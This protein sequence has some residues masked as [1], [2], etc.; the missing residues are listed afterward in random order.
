VYRFESHDRAG[1]DQTDGC[2][3]AVYA[4]RAG[5]L[6]LPFT[7]TVRLGAIASVNAE[8]IRRGVFA[9]AAD[10]IAYIA[11]AEYEVPAVAS[12]LAEY[13]SARGRIWMSTPRAIRAAL[14][15]RAAPDLL[16]RAVNRLATRNPEFSARRTLT[17]AQA[18]AAIVAAGVIAA[19]LFL[20]PHATEAAINVAAAGLFLA[21]LALRFVAAGSIHRLS[22]PPVVAPANEAGMPVYTVLV[23]LHREAELA[24]DVV[25]GLLNLD[26]PRE[27]L[28]VKLLVE[29]DDDATLPP[30]IRPCAARR[31]KSWWCRPDSRGRN[32]ARWP[33][34][35]RWRAER[36]S[37]CS[38]PRTGRTRSSSVR[39]GPLSGTGLPI[40]DACRR[41]L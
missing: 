13:P 37:R 21:V 19:A 16:D 36:S 22:A 12:W 39:H 27:K 4:E 31:S 20:A 9:L 34:H 18:I 23:P 25:R 7:E 10:G 32:R 33:M 24:G 17:P 11:P 38:M 3:A 5:R 14:T 40:W 1:V 41:R 28:D 6:M 35:C 8:A 26:W 15:E 29:T 30:R 2:E